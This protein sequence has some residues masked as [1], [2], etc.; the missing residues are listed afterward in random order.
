MYRPSILIS[1][2]P[3]IPFSEYVRIDASEYVAHFGCS[4]KESSKALKQAA[5]SLYDRYIHFTK[6]I[7]SDSIEEVYTRWIG[8][9]Q[10]DANY[11]YVKLMFTPIITETSKHLVL[12]NIGKILN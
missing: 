10:N 6:P 4:L 11:T 5:N 2:Q 7:E 12:H 3:V 9:L 8:Q 1:H